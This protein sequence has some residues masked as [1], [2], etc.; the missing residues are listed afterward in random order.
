MSVCAYIHTCIYI[1]M[2]NYVYMYRYIYMYT[3][4]HT[5]IYVFI[6]NPT[7]HY[8]SLAV[9][10]YRTSWVWGLNTFLDIYAGNKYTLSYLTLTTTLY[11]FITLSYSRPFKRPW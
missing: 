1:Y 5:C 4:T 3:H 6:F 11:N 10:I 9:I 8:R 2:Y 7:V